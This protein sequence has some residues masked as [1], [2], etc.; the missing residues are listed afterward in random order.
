[1]ALPDIHQI[2][3]PEWGLEFYWDIQFPY[4]SNTPNIPYPFNTWFPATDVTEVIW[5]PNSPYLVEVGMQ[6]FPIPKNVRHKTFSITFPDDVFNTLEKWFD[7]WY[8]S[9]YNINNNYVSVLEEIVRTVI[10][11]KLNSKRDV[12]NTS[13]YL[14]FPTSS[15]EYTGK[16]A[17]N[18]RL[19]SVTMAIAGKI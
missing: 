4:S 18:V 2:K 1:M 16:S 5:N 14:L 17:G 11:K 15:F 12:I 19:Y 7:D 6:S 9:I 10:I 8:T 13:T 3:E